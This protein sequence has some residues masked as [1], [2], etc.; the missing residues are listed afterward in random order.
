MN[1][2]FPD[3]LSN[4]RRGRKLTSWPTG[5]TTM[6]W[7]NVGSTVSIPSECRNGGPSSHVTSVVETVSRPP[8][9]VFQTL[10]KS[11]EQTL[12]FPFP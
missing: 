10:P 7:T 9:W 1:S 12:G 6:T 4:S 3:I 2:R 5:V 11:F 8:W